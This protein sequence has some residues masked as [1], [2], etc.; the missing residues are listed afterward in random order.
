MGLAGHTLY[1][2]AAQGNRADGVPVFN[3]S[4]KLM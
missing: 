3:N 2:S 4:H 1:I